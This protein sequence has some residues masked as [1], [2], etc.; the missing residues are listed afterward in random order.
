MRCLLPLFA[1]L[2]LEGC[3][4]GDPNV[5]PGAVCHEEHPG[6]ARARS[7]TQDELAFLYAEIFRLRELG[8][9]SYGRAWEAIPENLKFLSAV[10]IHTGGR[11]P[12]IYFCKS[13]GEAVVLSF[14]E[15]DSKNPQIV[16][17][18]FGANN[19]VYQ[20]LETQVLW[21]LER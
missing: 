18:Y 2:L 3:D 16:L 17:T 4:N 19:N 21:E 6:V 5:G 15:P 20:G 8:S 12:E 14:G 9:K 1:A 10:A 13:I 11:E 7:L